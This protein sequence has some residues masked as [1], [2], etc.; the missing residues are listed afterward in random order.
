MSVHAVEK[1]LWDVCKNPESH[2]SY[3]KN[4]ADFVQRY[5]LSNAEKHMVRGLEVEALTAHQVNLLLIMMT[6]NAI[7]WGPTRSANTSEDST[8]RSVR[9]THRNVSWPVS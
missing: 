3:R 5:P 7:A 8:H 2:A 4:P 9:F 1:S 6:W